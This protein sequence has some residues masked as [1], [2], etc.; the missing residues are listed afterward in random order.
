MSTIGLCMIV[1]NEAKVILRCLASVLSLID[2]VLVVDTGSDDGTQELIRGYL[3]DHNLKGTVID[4]PWRNFA[5]NRTFALER[6]RE[7]EPVDYAMMIDADDVLIPDR[8]FDAAAFKAQMDQDLFDVELAQGGISYY[9]P[10]ICRNQ[11][12]FRFKGVLHE[13]LEFP[14]G[15][16]T[17]QTAQGFRVVSGREGAR[18]QNPRKYQDDA[19]VLENALVTETDPF[20]ISRYTFYLAQSY[21]DCGER[22]KALEHYLRRSEQGFW[23]EEVYV[24]LFEAGNLMADLDRAFEEVVAVYERATQSVP[25]RAEALHAA[26]R[27]CRNLGR[28]AQGQEYAR[29][30][31]GINK[32]VGLFV[33][34]WVYD[35][36]LLDEFSVNA[37]WAGA[38]QESLDACMKLLAVEGLSE[39]TVKR[40]ASNAQFAVDKLRVQ[41]RPTSGSPIAE[42]A[43]Q[44]YG[45]GHLAKVNSDE[46][47]SI[48]NIT[49]LVQPLSSW[50]PPGPA[51]GT[52]LMIKGLEDRIPDVLAR[53]Q[54]QVNLFPDN[55]SREKP[56]VMWMHHDSNQN[57]VQW[58]RNPALVDRVTCFVFVSHWQRERY[59]AEFDIAPSK[60]V[61]LRNATTLSRQQRNWMKTDPLRFAYTSMPFRGLSVLL[62]AWEQLD[63]GNA[64]LHIWSSMRLYDQDDMKYQPLYARAQALNRVIYHGISPNSELKIA[65][66]DI[67][68]LA[69]PSTFAETSCLAV[70]DA[71]AAG[72]RV[73]VPARG[74]L[75]ETTSGFAHVYPWSADPIEHAALFGSAVAKEVEYPWFDTPEMSLTQQSYCEQFYDWN[76]RVKEWKRLIERLTED[77]PKRHSPYNEQIPA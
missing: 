75:P 61:V 37:Y 47:S 23:A 44:R 48:S 52:E 72:C 43:L 16:I 30:G 65:L 4:E 56:L 38:Y 49:P 76:Q 19:A 77:A 17:R 40:V 26:S 59:Q 22:D 58:C 60:C 74:A 69:Y 53:V 51:A 29:R 9:R 34:P 13:Y 70:I 24:S 64:E 42:K 33:Q 14:P 25:T 68:F 21:K 54:L 46:R 55:P 32:P 15:P 10:Q 63:L 28:Y 27:Y 41:D 11:L 39:N 12:P 50:T 6:L 71:M 36:G 5:Y 45:L 62:D 3:A 7:L 2:Y 57:A 8:N 67:H 20:L 31:L 35:Y 73:I 18:S 1:K 66:R